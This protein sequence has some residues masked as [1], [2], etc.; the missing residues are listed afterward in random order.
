MN[1]YKFSLTIL[2]TAIGGSVS[3]LAFAP[4]HYWWLLPLCLT[5]VFYWIAKSSKIKHAFA[6]GWAF[7][8]S[9]FLAGLWWIY[10]ALSGHIGFHPI[11]AFILTALM[12]GIF[13]VIPATVCTLAASFKKYQHRVF[14]LAALWTLSEW[15]RSWVLTG[16]P[17]LLHGYSQIPNYLFADWAPIIGII[18]IGLVLHCAIACILI[19]PTIS[20]K[21]RIKTGVVVAFLLFAPAVINSSWTWTYLSGDMSVSLVQGNV[22][23]DL[24]WHEARV[25]KA[26]EDYIFIAN[27]EES[28]LLIMPETALPMYLEDLPSGY[29]QELR[30]ASDK[31]NNMLII[32]VFM[33]D[34]QGR[35]YNSALL[36]EPHKINQYHKTHL[37]PYGEFFPMPDFLRRL[38]R[39]NGI[40]F[41]DLSPG[42]YKKSS[43]LPNGFFAGISICY[44]I[45]F[46]DELRKQLPTSNVLINI[47]NDGWFDN[48]LMPHQHLQISQARALESGRWV[49]RS[50]NTGITAI[51]N[52][53]GQIVK[54]LPPQIEGILKHRFQM[55]SGITP[56]ILLGDLS[57][58]A[59][60]SLILLTLLSLLLIERYKRKQSA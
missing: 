40:P 9:Y 51:I 23:Q 20:N 16:F 49:L 36:V 41:A 6:Y 7:G 60:C 8:F 52:D 22:K 39:A 31:N 47:T 58:V 18:G 33:Q 57:A 4:T 48:S 12:C 17:W 54:A 5:V 32:G 45:A 56:Y 3:T 38:L 37:V 53:K 43:K 11:V 28:Q 50:A 30:R 14:A 1:N 44:E 59:V 35:T 42:L 15:L 46:G 29:L 27:N 13:A 10:E 34:E 55:R 2:L 24:K 19:L 25:M 26:L 21:S